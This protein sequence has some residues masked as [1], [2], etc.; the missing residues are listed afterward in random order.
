M[1]QRRLG[2]R[3]AA[4]RRL[5]DDWEF[6]CTPAGQCVTPRDVASA[7]PEWLPT[8]VPSTAAASLRALGRWSLN[9]PPRRF[10]DVDW[11]Y[12]VRV[13]V[14]A[15]RAPLTL[16]LDGLATAATVWLDDREL[17]SSRNMFLRHELPLGSP[18]PGAHALVIRFAALDRLLKERRPRPR[19]RTPMVENQQLR[20]WRTTLLGRTPGWSPPAAAVGP[21]RDVWLGTSA[22]SSLSAID[23]DC[24][25]EGTTGVLALRA[26][27]DGDRCDGLRLELRRLGEVFS[28]PIDVSADQAATA[29]LRV[30]NVAKWWPHTH[31][32]PALYDAY[33]CAADGSE[34]D[35]GAV[36][37]RRVSLQTTATEFRLFIN[38]VPVFCR[39][40]CWT[41]PDPVSLTATAAEYE[42]M[43]SL[44]AAAGM[45]TVR[46]VGTMT[47]ES[48]A[49]FD[50]CDARGI[51]VWQDLMF[52]NMDY[53]ADD[54][55]F[56]QSVTEEVRQTI[57]DLR[58]RPCLAV[59][60]GNSEVEQQAAMWGT[61]RELWT[62]TLF[63]GPIAELARSLS[64]AVPY[65]P[66]SAHGGSFPHDPSSGTTSYYGVGAYQL[67]MH[68]RR[69]DAPVFATECL[70]LANVPE[71]DSLDEMLPGADSRV[72][73]ARWHERAPRDL[74]AGWDFDDVRDRYFAQ[75]FGMAPAAVRYAD[76]ERYLALSRLVSAELMAATMAEWRSGPSR[77][78]GAL[79]LFLRDLWPGAG[80]GILDSAGRPKAAWY[81]LRRVLQPLGVTIADRGCA[82]LAVC[83]TSDR[84]GVVEGHLEVTTYRDGTPVGTIGSAP[85]E[86]AAHATVVVSAN[87][88]FDTWQDLSYV[89]RFGPPVHDTVVARLRD[90]QG[91]VLAECGYRPPGVDV[92]SARWDDVSITVDRDHDQAALIVSASR[93]VRGLAL[94]LPGATFS[95]NYVDLLPGSAALRLV[96]AGNGL[97]LGSRLILRAANITRE[98]VLHWTN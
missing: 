88:L 64:P 71:R 89:Y 50:A 56:L 17:L 83:V 95:D 98:R 47:Y 28:A 74:G 10:D 69:N 77:C 91:A 21:W 60:C 15:P 22:G 86:I 23:L 37:F 34:V 67:S 30:E 7:G 42:R 43:L 24:E 11:W 54:G 40:V 44:V 80:W 14:P 57:S 3:F 19:W 32:E 8:T 49:F 1:E 93:Y 76:H 84:P 18:E 62:P 20:W 55:D 29:V 61:Q 59:I 85:I 73:Q 26:R 36:G 4:V 70:A 39:G 13:D 66:S 87:E 52:A 45:N 33:L 65:W 16:G 31:G 92:P 25:L 9:G 75:L 38:D 58:R 51:L 53:P 5:H 94:E 27:C 6:C 63:H 97:P 68:E 79:V 72:H 35:L 2:T 90:R 82:G 46:V 41:P 81:G 12:R 78:R 48:D 96:L